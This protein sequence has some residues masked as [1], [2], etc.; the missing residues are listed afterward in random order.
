ME[1]AY[2]QGNEAAKANDQSFNTG[3][4]IERSM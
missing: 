2:K 1:A 3:E 4:N